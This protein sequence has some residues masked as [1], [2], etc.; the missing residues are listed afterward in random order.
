[1]EV[2]V[3]KK[4]E[5]LNGG[6]PN[7]KDYQKTYEKFDWEDAEKHFSWSETGKVNMAYECVDKHVD[8]G[9][10]SN[11]ALRYV[12]DDGKQ[13]LTFEEMKKQTNKFANVLKKHGVNKG[14]RVFIFMPRSPEL[15]VAFL[16][17]IKAGAIIGP[18]FEAFMK[19]AVYDR[20]LDSGAK[21]LV[22]TPEMQGRVPKEDLPELEKTILVGEKNELEDDEVIYHEEMKDASEDFEVVWVDRETPMLLHYT[23]GST[24]K[25]KGVV[26]VHNA[27]IGHYMTGKWLLDLHEDDVYWCTADP[28]WVTGTS[29]GIFAPLLNGVA[30]LIRGGRFGADAWYKTIQDEKVTIWYSAPT[31]FRMLMSKGKEVVDKYDTSSL[32]L[33]YS[34]GEPLNPEVI[35]WGMDVFGLPMHDNWW[36]TE[37]GMQLISNYPCMD[38]RLGSMGKPFPGITAGII[39]EEGNELGPNEVGQ[40]AI[41]AGWPSMMRSIWNNREKYES[42]FEKKPWYVS[43]DSAHKDEDG[44]FWFHGRIDDVIKTSGERVGPF[45]VES[46]LVEHPAVAEAGVIGKPDPMRGQIIKAFIKLRDGYAPSDELKKEITEFVKK[47]LAAHAKP[48]EIEF[49]DKLPK[50][51]SGKIMRRVLKAKELGLPTGDLSTLAD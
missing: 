44:Y 13:E 11:V 9:N 21:V 35:R 18:L 25:P 50:T 20:L 7:M 32:R 30:T 16:G 34:V 6:K 5:K 39:D 23:S 42:Y 31:A 48:R 10:G 8:K 41:K 49:V 22:T 47:G 19:E 43:G 28:G 3:I 24:G 51:R 17:T 12:S 37:T 45:E 14:D 40:L 2:E 1:M 38:I 15:Y 36:M 33:I 46:K 29:Y 27:M 4:D 26:H